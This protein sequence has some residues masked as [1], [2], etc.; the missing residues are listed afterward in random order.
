MWSFTVKIPVII[1]NFMVNSLTQ[2]E[3]LVAITQLKVLW[4][5][6]KIDKVRQK[7]L[8]RSSNADDQH[9]NTKEHKSQMPASAIIHKMC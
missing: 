1:N 7:C 3:T 4:N 5:G 9:L 8:I 6:V 2:F